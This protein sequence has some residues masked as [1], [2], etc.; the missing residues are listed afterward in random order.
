MSCPHD[1]LLW[2]WT[3]IAKVAP[4]MHLRN[5]SAGIENGVIDFD[6]QGHLA[7]STQETAFN[8]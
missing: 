4:N 8:V 7:L 2:V 6:L 1:N 5:L 3:R